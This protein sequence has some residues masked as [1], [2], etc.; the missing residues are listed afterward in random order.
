MIGSYS[1]QQKDAQKHSGMTFTPLYKKWSFSLK[2][3]SVNAFQWI[4]SHLL[5][6][7]LV[8]TSFFV[9]CAEK[10]FQEI[11]RVSLI[12]YSV[13]R[14]LCKF[15]FY[16]QAVCKILKQMRKTRF[17]YYSKGWST[18]VSR[19]KTQDIKAIFVNAAQ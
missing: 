11:L 12:R 5:K 4:W 3:S 2:I 10:L 15:L 17:F 7:S 6:K 1:C 19:G 13:K 18:S 8:K 9:Q 16:F 14:Y